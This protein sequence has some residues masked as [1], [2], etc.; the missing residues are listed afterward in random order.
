MELSAATAAAEILAQARREKTTIESLPDHLKPQNLDDA[1]EIQ[2]AL[3]PLIEDLSNGKAAG[4]KA[5]ATTEEAQQ[6]F[7]LNTPFRGVLVSSYML[8]NGA[9]ILASDCSFRILEAE[10]AFRLSEDL[11][12]AAAPYDLGGVQAAVGSVMT[13]IEVV[14]LRYEGGMAAGGLQIVA[15]NSAAGYW[16]KGSDIEDLDA[17]NFEDWPVTLHINGAQAV[18]GNASNV[19][20]NPFNSLTWLANYLC[21][22]GGGLKAGDIV[23]AGSCVTPTPAPR[24]EVKAVADFGSLGKVTVNFSA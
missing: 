15:D 2:N 12:A 7:G 21:Q 14:D 11:P 6:N 20:G 13:S 10:F 5:G 19:L 22:Q 23:T 8:E 4:Y 16:I 17:V 3:I 24:G 18:E 1:Y 9:T